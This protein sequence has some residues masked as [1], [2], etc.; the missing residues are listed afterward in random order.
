MSET[1]EDDPEELESLL[2]Q[3]QALQVRKFGHAHTCGGPGT[4][5]LRMCGR[6]VIAGDLQALSDLEGEAA[7]GTAATARA[8]YQ[9]LHRAA[10]QSVLDVQALQE[11]VLR[12]ERQL[13]HV[14]LQQDIAA[15]CEAEGCTDVVQL[16]DKYREEQEQAHLEVGAGASPR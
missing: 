14:L 9:R 15:A 1:R 3:A 6:T 13:Q 5:D 11:R 8:G 2:S 12:L 10:E 16:L 7:Q 4:E